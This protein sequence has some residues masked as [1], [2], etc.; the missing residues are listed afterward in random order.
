[1]TYLA[2]TQAAKVGPFFGA[3]I[4]P[5]CST[6]GQEKKT[7]QNNF[8][9]LL[10]C[11]TSW[12]NNGCGLRCTELRSEHSHCSSDDDDETNCCQCHL[13]PREK[14]FLFFLFPAPPL[15]FC[16]GGSYSIFPLVPYGENCVSVRLKTARDTGSYDAILDILGSPQKATKQTNGCALAPSFRAF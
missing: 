11:S 14:F 6:G 1:M 3:T 13:P 16:G 5:T 8:L 4:I 9:F 10:F 7:F 2:L 15:P 12:Q